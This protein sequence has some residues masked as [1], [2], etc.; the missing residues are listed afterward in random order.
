MFAAVPHT[1]AA[2][3]MLSLFRDLLRA[4]RKVTSAALPHPI[5]GVISP[6]L[7]D[8]P[9]GQ[10]MIFSTTVSPIHVKGPIKLGPS[11]TKM[12]RKCCCNTRG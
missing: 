8:D 5:A 4:G 3:S 7:W 12:N 1:A 6:Q 11:K 10:L 9:L 2:E